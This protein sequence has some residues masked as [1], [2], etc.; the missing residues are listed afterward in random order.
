MLYC[1][2]KASDFEKGELRLF[3]CP[4]CG[5]ALKESEKF[6]ICPDSH[7]FDKAKK[8]YVNLLL[9][10]DGSLHGDSKTM[11]LAR[12]E[13]MESGLYSPLKD[14]IVS[15]L[16]S[17]LSEPELILDCG[18]GECYYTSAVAE[19]FENAEILGTDISKD[20]L[21]VANRR[22]GRIKRAVAS[23]FS[24][25]VK[26]ESVDALLNIF[27]PFVSSE[28][29]RVLKPGGL[30]LMAIPLEEHLWEMKKAVYEK[31]YKN[32][33]KPTKLNGFTLAYEKEISYKREVENPLLTRLFEM[34]PYFIKTSK[35]DIE[36]LKKISALSLT[37]SFKILLYKKG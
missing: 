10:R 37:F 22:L 20:I 14:S 1:F 34:T 2:Y 11:A 33:P 19:K 9:G 28:F 13:I 36:K 24:L 12:F 31:P 17:H 27:S 29:L 8:G 32:E 7:L 4:V 35:E 6:F 23:S 30:L 26:D 25:P 15:A 21:S 3:I 16:A 18:C 5:K